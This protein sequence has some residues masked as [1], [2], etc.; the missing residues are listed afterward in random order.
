[1][2]QSIRER[3][4]LPKHRKFPIQC[5][6]IKSI[7]HINGKMRQFW[8]NANSLADRTLFRWTLLLLLYLYLTSSPFHPILFNLIKF[9]RYIMVNRTLEKVL[10]K[11]NWQAIMCARIEF[12]K[13]IT[14][15][16]IESAMSIVSVYYC[17]AIHS[18]RK[19]TKAHCLHL[20]PLSLFVTIFNFN[21]LLQLFLY[22]NPS[23]LWTE[24]ASRVGY[25]G[26][27]NYCQHF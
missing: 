14:N 19:K 20:L 2:P 8:L 7:A 6:E 21:S 16:D 9:H 4:K 27:N 25:Y 10:Q 5:N 13:F 15:F 24:A 18:N 26:Y 1:M 23:L 12:G 22:L 17:P 3:R 11:S